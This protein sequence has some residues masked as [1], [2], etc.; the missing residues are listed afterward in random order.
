[1]NPLDMIDPAIAARIRREEA[2]EA[3]ALAW[4]Q[5]EAAWEAEHKRE[6]L[7]EEADQF[8]RWHGYSLAEYEQM[9]LAQAERAGERDLSAPVGSPE[10]P[11]VMLDGR[12][13]RTSAPVARSRSDLDELLARSYRGPSEVMAFE[14]ARF[15]AKREQM[16]R[17][18]FEREEAYLRRQLGY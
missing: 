9:R 15:D 12:S 18:E 10:N 5:R 14:V 16:R 17:A 2:Q 1:V 3:H 13:V 7:A 8:Q 4:S 6:R 11:D